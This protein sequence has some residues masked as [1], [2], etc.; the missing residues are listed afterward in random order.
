VILQLLV[1]VLRQA[2]DKGRNLT[3][4]P[5]DII[6]SMI[7]FGV[8]FYSNTPDDTHCFQASIRSVLKYFLPRK[9]FGWAKLDKMTAKK[10][11]L[12]TWPTQGLLTLKKMGFDIVDMEDFDYSA[13]IQE[14]GE[15]L[16]EKYGEEVA[17]EQIKNSDIA[18]E[19]RL[20]REF[21]KVFGNQSKLPG[22]KD[23][24][25]FLDKGYLVICNVNAYALDS[26]NGFAGH[27][28]VV[29]GYN[30]GSLY[31]HDP[32]SPPRKDRK[33]SFKRFIEAWAFPDEK[34]KN[35]MAFRYKG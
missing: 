7:K 11:G 25:N 4:V 32:G 31:L 5:F 28:V 14:G 30:E 34:A 33:V 9:E 19:K 35:L 27:F 18:Q 10:K 1:S 2:Q 16:I 3:T 12:W 29:I 15:Y 13:F 6:A 24:K 21:V 26:E 17:K 20:A 23:I 22:I 8:P